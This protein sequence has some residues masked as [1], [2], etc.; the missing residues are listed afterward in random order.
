MKSGG[1]RWESASQFLYERVKSLDPASQFLTD[2][3]REQVQILLRAACGGG[4]S[5][6]W[7]PPGARCS[8]L[9]LTPAGSRVS[10]SHASAS[11]DGHTLARRLRRAGDSAG[12]ARIRVDLLDGEEAA[13]RHD[14]PGSR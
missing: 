1:L 5:H 10:S 14:I 2:R 11:W 6:L 4:D 12:F 8:R 13:N 7:R 3:N 9:V